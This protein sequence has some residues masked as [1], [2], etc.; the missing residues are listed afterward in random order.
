MANFKKF[1]ADRG[2]LVINESADAVTLTLVA[3]NNPEEDTPFLVAADAFEELDYTELAA[4]IRFCISNYEFAGSGGYRVNAFVEIKNKAKESGL[5]LSNAVKANSNN[6]IFY[7]LKD[8]KT[9]PREVG[10][11]ENYMIVI[12][13]DVRISLQLVDL[14]TSDYTSSTRS[15][16]VNFADFLQTVDDNK[17][18][19]FCASAM[20]LAV[21]NHAGTKSNE[22]V[23]IYLI[24]ALDNLLSFDPGRTVPQNAIGRLADLS[25]EIWFTHRQIIQHYPD[26]QKEATQLIRSKL[27]NSRWGRCLKG[28]AV[29]MPMYCAHFLR[30]REILDAKV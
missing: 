6:I 29:N 1:L 16:S 28:R 21:K 8:N 25:Q 5:E 14:V 10:T 26:K 11:L 24:K 20:F 23:T 17:K 12:K 15:K 9:L 19:L 22:R 27:E 4:Y 2:R 3:D 18:I 7:D 30:I 13:H